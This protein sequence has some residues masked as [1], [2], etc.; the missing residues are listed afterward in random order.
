MP[1]DPALPGA[2]TSAARQESARAAQA[3]ERARA[4]A[5][6]LAAKSGKKSPA[7]VQHPAQKPGASPENGSSP[8]AVKKTF[9]T[10]ATVAPEDNTV[11]AAGSPRHGAIPKAQDKYDGKY[12]KY[13]SSV[14]WKLRNA[15]Y[16]PAQTRPGIYYATAAITI[17][18]S[19]KILSASLVDS[20]GDA[21]LDKYMLQGIRRAGK[22]QP[23][24]EGLGNSLDLTFTFVRQ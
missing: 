7:A 2:D 4:R 1:D 8:A 11:T 23:P 17:D 24:P 13:I 21:L 14:V 19:G 12:D 18:K 3:N 6:A 16:V 10:N 9:A 22:I 15:M 20:S 5:E